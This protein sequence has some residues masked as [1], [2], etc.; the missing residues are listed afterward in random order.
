MTKSIVLLAMIFVSIFLFGDKAMSSDEVNKSEELVRDALSDPIVA[1]LAKALRVANNKAKEAGFKL[2]ESS[3]IIRK[4]D[5][6]WMIKYGPKDENT[7]G[8]IM[9]I[10]VDWEGKIKGI[11]IGE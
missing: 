3:I 7:L 8:G 10:E 2:E 4:K 11:D 9:A 1:S 5:D 6:F